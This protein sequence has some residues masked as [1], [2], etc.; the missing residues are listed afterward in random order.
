MN[1]DDVY[2]V[3]WVSLFQSSDGH[4]LMYLL[5]DMLSKISDHEMLRK[6][7]HLLVKVTTDA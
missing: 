6:V 3:V 5:L 4:T 2:I 1:A 7:K